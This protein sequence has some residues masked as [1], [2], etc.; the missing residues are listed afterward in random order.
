MNIFSLLGK[1]VDDSATTLS[2]FECWD[3]NDSVIYTCLDSN[4]IKA[5][6]DSII[7]DENI[8]GDCFIIFKANADC[9]FEIDTVGYSD[10]EQKVGERIAQYVASLNLT[11]VYHRLCEEAVNNVTG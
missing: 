6:I 11:D 3:D 5:D 8:V 1:I 4:Y 2:K 7:D 9:H 10:V